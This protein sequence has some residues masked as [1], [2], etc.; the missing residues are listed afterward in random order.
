[1]SLRKM[2]ADETN[3][4]LVA[5]SNAQRSKYVNVLPDD[6]FQRII[7]LESSRRR[8]ALGAGL[9]GGAAA[10]IT[11]LMRPL[12]AGVLSAHL[13]RATLPDS[14][15]GSIAPSQRDKILEWVYRHWKAPMFGGEITPR[16]PA[17]ASAEAVR[18][19]SNAQSPLDIPT[20]FFD[21]LRRRR[22][23]K[24]LG[25]WG[26]AFL[27]LMGS[28]LAMRHM[29]NAAA[30]LGLA[31]LLTGGGAMA[32]RYLLPL[33]MTRKPYSLEQM[34]QYDRLLSAIAPIPE[35]MVRQRL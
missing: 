16:T 25:T 12:L 31:A 1:M 9:A 20:P 6:L 27:G 21:Y 30:M 8:R 15:V 34:E 22:S 2:A 32:G 14:Y 35:R 4:D 10:A 26:G 5:D 17:A 28:T 7:E 29:Q 11:G 23:D 18:R 19:S 3:L 24:S 33:I 13:G